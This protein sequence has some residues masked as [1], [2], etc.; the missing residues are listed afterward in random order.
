VNSVNTRGRSACTYHVL[1]NNVE[2]PISSG[3][4]VGPAFRNAL[5]SGDRNTVALAFFFASLDQDPQRS[6]K[7][8]IIDDPMT[9]LDEHRSLITIQEMRRLEASVSQMI[10]LSHSKPFLC[11][12][13]E[14]ADKY[15][16]TA[17]RID[18]DTTGSTLAAWDVNQDCI[19]EHDRRHNLVREYMRTGNPTNERA[20]A[21]ALRPILESFIR[22]AYPNFTTSR[23][24]RGRLRRSTIAS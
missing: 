8:V 6:H 19:T 11:G 12:L 22:V 14:G 15:T 17:I 23:T 3:D 18:R 2:V 10:V 4:T 5:S 21:Q 7:I 1:I 13:W 9:S 24:P 20:V 16:R